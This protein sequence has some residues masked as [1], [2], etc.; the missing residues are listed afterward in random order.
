MTTYDA[1]VIERHDGLDEPEDGKI[2]ITGATEIYKAAQTFQE[3]GL[4]VL[5]T[6]LSIAL[7]IVYTVRAVAYQV[8]RPATRHHR[9]EVRQCTL[10]LL[11]D[12]ML[13]IPHN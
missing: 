4:Y 3:L 1:V 8:T 10:R 11:R 13:N 5:L 6:A 2:V 7:Q 9:Y 12:Q